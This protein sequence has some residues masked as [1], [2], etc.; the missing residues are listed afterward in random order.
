MALFQVAYGLIGL[1][2]MQAQKQDLIGLESL[3]TTYSLPAPAS[4]Q[5][6]HSLQALLQA[7]KSPASLSA[8]SSY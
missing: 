1:W 4:K 8:Y 7:A 5:G 2:D 6:S 3:L